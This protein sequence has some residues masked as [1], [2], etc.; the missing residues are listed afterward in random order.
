MSNINE[1]NKDLIENRIPFGLLDEE[2]QE[3]MKAWEHGTVFWA[4]NDGVFHDRPQDNYFWDTAVYRAKPAP[5]RR[6]YK[7]GLEKEND[8][9]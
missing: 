7:A 6:E 8:N 1:E 9:D 5:E 2:T 4:H 3:R